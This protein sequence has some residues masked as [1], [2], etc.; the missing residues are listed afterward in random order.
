M[1]SL[2]WKL[3]ANKIGAMNKAWA[4]SIDFFF[5]ENSLLNLIACEDQVYL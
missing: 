3:L 4:F 1:V 5:G 2:M